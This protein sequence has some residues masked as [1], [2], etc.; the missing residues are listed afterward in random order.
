M[1]SVVDR[2][3]PGEVRDAVIATLRAYPDGV[4]VRQIVADVRG[5]IGEDVA[6]SS[7]RSYLRL[8]TPELFRRLD[9]GQY[10]LEAFP[11]RGNGREREGNTF[12]SVVHDRATVVHGDCMAWLRKRDPGTIQAVVTDPPYG[13]V[14]YSA[15][16][17][18]KLRAGKGGVWR[19]PPSFDGVRRSPLPRFTVL[20]P[21]DRDELG[22]FFATWAALLAPV[23]VPGAN[24]V[25]A[26]NP[27]LSYIVS[28]ALAR[29]GL[30]R[31]G[32]IVR[33]V[34]TMRGGDRPKGAHEEFAEV[35]VMPRSMWEPWL[36]FR[37]PLE[38]RVQ[39]NLRKWSTGGFRRPSAKHPFGD[40]IRSAP[41]RKAERAL[42]PHPSL[43]PQEFLRQVVRGVLPLGKGVVLDP[44]CGAGSTLAAANA[45]GYESV[46][47]ERDV[48][49]YEMARRAVPQL[50]KY[51]QPSE[52]RS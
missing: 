29:A 33:L 27:L 30:E 47:I 6:D 45:V 5:L 18:S 49:Y 10:Q 4:P 22:R 16:E 11:E 34:T 42:A 19:I 9:R 44:F 25:V 23:L 26:T 2:R 52:G 1:Q 24:V 31:R 39:D 43:K 14:E 21:S 8:N 12:E 51:G 50:S 37:K 40:V 13:L 20:S 38:G 35:S 7:I 46:G 48:E 28:G 41:T 17:Q 32:E 36:V 15:K 3:Q